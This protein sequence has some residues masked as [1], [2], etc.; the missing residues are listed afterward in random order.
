[1]R[2]WSSL[3]TD[4]VGS[5]EKAVAPGDSACVEL[6]ERHHAAV[7]RSGADAAHRFSDRGLH[8]LKGVPGA[9]QLFT[10]EQSA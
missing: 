7:R 4:I 1:M 6:F 2:E 3:F 10:V 5:T 8:E 9:L